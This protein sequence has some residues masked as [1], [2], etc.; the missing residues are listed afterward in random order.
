MDIVQRPRADMEF[1]EGELGVPSLNDVHDLLWLAG[2]PMPPR[3]LTYQLAA[4]RNIAVVEDVNLHLVWEPGRIFLKPLPRYLLNAAFWT[5]HLAC[6][7]AAQDNSSCVSGVSL[8]QD[9]PG[10]PSNAL[11]KRRQLYGCA[12]GFLLSY[13]ALIQ[14]ESDY[15]VAASNHLLP[16]DVDWDH[17][18]RPHGSFWRTAL[19]TSHGSTRG[20]DT[21]SCDCRDSTKFPAG[22]A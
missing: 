12:Y 7:T 8:Q 6:D 2:R 15:H 10:A 20:T 16:A 17:G 5:E 18:V 22:A 21:E 1:L 11:S 4:S 3:P 13:T 14:H 19:A 9:G